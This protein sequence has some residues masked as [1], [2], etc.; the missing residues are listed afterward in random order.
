MMKTILLFI[1]ICGVAL[2]ISC[3]HGTDQD[4][5]EI[6]FRY[7]NQLPIATT[8]TTINSSGDTIQP[9]A[10]LL[11]RDS[12]VYKKGFEFYLNSTHSIKFSFISDTNKCLLYSG[13]ILSDPTDPRSAVSYQ[14]I[15]VYRF[16]IDST[17]F[18]KATKCE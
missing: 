18:L 6:T 10:T 11:P 13:A 15:E 7:I 8:I 16:V 3:K 12:I 5:P 14:R 4:E 17:L 9:S 2:S 1:S